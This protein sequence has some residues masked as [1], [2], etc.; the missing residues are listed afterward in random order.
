MRA[1]QIFCYT[2]IL[3]ISMPS[4]LRLASAQ[5]VLQGRVSVTDDP[6]I[7]FDNVY[8][9]EVNAA[10]A[11]QITATPAWRTELECRTLAQAA[12]ELD[13]C[14]QL[15]MQARALSEQAAAAYERGRRGVAPNDDAARGNQLQNEAANLVVRA[16]QCFQP[17]LNEWQR[18]GG[19][20]V[21]R[22]SRTQTSNTCNLPPG[23]LDQLSRQYGAQPILLPTLQAFGL[24]RSGQV[25][26]CVQCNGDV[27]ACWPAMPA[28]AQNQPPAQTPP[29][30]GPSATNP[31]VP[32]TRRTGN[33]QPQWARLVQQAQMRS[34]PDQSGGHYTKRAATAESGAAIAAALCAA[35]HRVFGPDDGCAVEAQG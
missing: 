2:I 15:L 9:D 8:R 22:S 34:G 16:G 29:Q 4:V 11:Y 7:C 21:A 14:W 5:S 3:L 24:S 6:V 27:V 13:P 12:P 18:N 35:A 10:Q 28:A 17:I 23:E 25:H 1:R 32:S 30:G 31:R 20:Y 33:W 26:G 19:H